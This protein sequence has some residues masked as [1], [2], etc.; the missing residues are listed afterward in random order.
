MNSFGL[1]FSITRY[2]CGKWA[3]RT[4][5]VYLIVNA[6]G[7]LTDW[8]E[9]I[10]PFYGIKPNKT[11]PAD[12]QLLFLQGFLPYQNEEVVVL[13]AV[14]FDTRRAADVHLVP[15][16]AGEVCVLMFDVTASLELRRELQQKSNDI[17]LLYEQELQSFQS[18]KQAYQQ[19][20]K[21][22][23]AAEEANK[24]KTELLSKISHDLKTP[25]TAI[26]GFSQLLNLNESSLNEEQHDFV[27]EIEKAGNYLL[28]LINSLLDAAKYEHKK[29][30]LNP[31]LLNPIKEINDLLVLLKPIA[32]KNQIALI[33]RMNKRLPNIWVDSMRFKQIMINFLSNAIKY[34]R[35][36]G[37]VIVN[38]YLVDSHTMR[39]SVKDTGIGIEIEQLDLV[40]EAYERG[41]AEN[42]NIEGTGIGLNVCKQLAQVMNGA[43]GVCSNVDSGSLFWVDLP[44]DENFVITPTAPLQYT[45]LYIDDN[46]INID[47]IQNLLEYRD[48]YHLINISNLSAAVKLLILDNQIPD[49]ILINVNFFKESYLEFVNLIKSHAS[50]ENIPIIPIFDKKTDPAEI[51]IALENGVYDYLYQPFDF[52]LT[53]ILFNELVS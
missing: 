37:C 22:R 29:I 15:A 39:I 23:K 16:E 36:G 13:E 43:V 4:I 27:N 44:I 11:Q 25:L 1:P 18:L 21:Q 12:E 26:I 20:E 42:S 40:F 53:M 52:G 19:A 10:T 8:S 2:L 9:N 38:N 49:A 24:A 14:N 41:N 30:E 45:V 34:N 48:D 32:D 5:F 50:S 17:Q 35:Q 47:L 46:P 7:F 28:G 51:K 31:Q 33:D 3:E 6:D